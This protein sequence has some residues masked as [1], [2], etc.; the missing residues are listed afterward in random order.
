VESFVVVQNALPASE[1]KRWRQQA[2]RISRLARPIVRN[3][4]GAELV[5][6]VVTG[7]QIY[8][9]WPE[10]FTFYESKALH[11]WIAVVTGEERIFRS[12]HLESGLNLNVMEGRGSVYRWHFDAIP[13][14]ALF[15][16][17]DAKLEDGGALEVVVSDR[18]HKVP[19]V[20]EPDTIRVWPKGGMMVL[21]DGTRCYHHVT[22]IL[23][24]G[25]RL[26]IPMVFPA[27]IA[28]RPAG[29]DA[30]LYDAAA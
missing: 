12:N 4:N 29:L 22:P 13:Y 19:V 1:T 10:L 2:T 5:Y 8:S 6:R 23:K 18:P 21:M 27:K 14:T 7:T 28:E 11:E 26:S 15:Y 25:L 30:Y 3:E 20:C 16:L 24:R 9:H 17:T